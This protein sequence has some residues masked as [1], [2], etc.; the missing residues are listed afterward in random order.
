M[1]DPKIA[2]LATLGM[3]T[4]TAVVGSIHAADFSS[5]NLGAD[6]HADAA[7]SPAG[8]VREAERSEATLDSC[9]ETDPPAIHWEQCT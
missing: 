8:P 2:M 7:S 6:P 4:A 5:V 9:I 1:M 3:L